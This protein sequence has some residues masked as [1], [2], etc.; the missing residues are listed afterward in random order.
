MNDRLGEYDDSIDQ[1]IARS[2][3]M[4]QQKHPDFRNLKHCILRQGQR[5]YKIAKY[6]TIVDRHT[7]EVHHHALML[8]TLSRTKTNGWQIKEK[9]SITLTDEGRNEIQILFDFVATSSQI[10]GDTH[11]TVIRQDDQRITRILEAITATGQRRELIEQILTWVESE[12]SATRNLVEFSAEQPER[13]RS[14]IAALNYGYY[15]RTLNRFRQLIQA[16]ELERTYQSFLEENYWIFGS[17]FSQLVQGR[18]LI[19][20]IQFDFPLRRTADEYL[21]VIEIKRPIIEAL[22]VG[23]RLAPR[24]ELSE[25]IAQAEEYLDLLDRESDRIWRQYEIRADKVRAKI[26]IGRD[27]DKRQLDALRRHN[28]NRNRVE[29]L[30]FDQL[31]RVGQRILNILASE[32]TRITASVDLDNDIPF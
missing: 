2:V 29:V 27:G 24:A 5:S 6:W 19:A 15:S 25:A 10:Q 16:N 11:Y 23:E 3:E 20:N 18:D 17:E 1:V 22:F 9:N 21:E 26:V 28:A 14:L 13:S 31:L 30:T 8:E 12:P 4:D 32:N 7:G